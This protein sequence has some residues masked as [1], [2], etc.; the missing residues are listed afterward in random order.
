MSLS[1]SLGA[2]VI[3]ETGKSFSKVKTDMREVNTKIST[4]DGKLEAVLALF[5]KFNDNFVA[6]GLGLF[7]AF[8]EICTAE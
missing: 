2:L 3:R 8:V 4:I 6:L 1:Q 5:G 7:L